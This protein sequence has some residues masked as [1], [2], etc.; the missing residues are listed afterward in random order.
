MK[1]CMYTRDGDV[2]AIDWQAA[3]AVGLVLPAQRTLPPIALARA[4]PARAAQTAPSPPAAPHTTG[5]VPG[6]GVTRGFLCGHVGAP[7]PN[8]AAQ[9]LQIFGHVLQSDLGVELRELGHARRDEA[10]L[11]AHVLRRGVDN[12]ALQVGDKARNQS[13]NQGLS[14]GSRTAP[15]LKGC[16]RRRRPPSRPSPPFNAASR[17]ATPHPRSGTLAVA[18]VES[19]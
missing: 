15:L 11:G 5:H 14:C 7:V 4:A 17:A 13:V 3:L 8:P 18:G 9:L 19:T 6:P 16:R 10:E 2:G 1:S 12:R